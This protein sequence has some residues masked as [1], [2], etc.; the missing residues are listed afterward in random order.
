MNR[1][2]KL[3]DRH[4]IIYE[5]DMI[6]YCYQRLVQ[7]K[8][9]SKREGY[10]FLECFLLHYRNLIEFL[11]KTRSLRDDDLSISKPEDW[12]GGLPIGEDRI[13]PLVANELYEEYEGRDKTGEK[14]RDTISRYLQHCTK[15]RTESKDWPV[16]EMYRKIS[17]FIDG[18]RSV[19]GDS[20]H[21]A[22]D[23]GQFVVGP[24][25]AHAAT[26]RTFGSK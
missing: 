10:A 1:P 16:E 8:R 11:G 23:D 2:E 14:R 22:V 4:T 21:V 3:S 9:L 13:K 24:A 17:P 26:I 5:I 7:E 25:G 19:L 20:Q 15:Q 12:A 6:E 18:F